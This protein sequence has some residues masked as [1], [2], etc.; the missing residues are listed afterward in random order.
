[1]C[2]RVFKNQ[3]SDS[4]E[5]PFYKI[6]T[7]GG[8]PN[9][10]ISRD[11]YEKYKKQY[12]YP[13]KGDILISASG[14]IGRT[15]PFDDEQAYFQD[16]NIVWIDNDESLVINRYLLYYYQIVKWKT[17]GGTIKRL[18][19]K[20]IRQTRIPVPSLEK[21]KEIVGILDQFDALVNDLTIGIPAEIKARHQQ[22]EYYQNQLLTF[23]EIA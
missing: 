6:G 4:G 19:N 10:F 9:A 3:T 14:T 13:K 2:K 5:I 21:Q 1:M 11:L 17:D 23:K 15:I 7:F 18:Y 16:S 22:L 20:N 12:S 8:S